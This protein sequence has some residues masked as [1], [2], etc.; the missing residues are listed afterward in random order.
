MGVDE[1]EEENGTMPS[2]VDERPGVAVVAAVFDGEGWPRDGDDLGGKGSPHSSRPSSPSVPPVIGSSS[3]SSD[4]V[5]EKLTGLD[6]LACRR[7]VPTRGRSGVRRASSVGD[8]A[9]SAKSS[10]QFSVS[11]CM[12]SEGG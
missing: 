10:S 9:C 4:S 6:V 11:G 2:M 12:G 5:H 1:D 3:P 8:E 7:R